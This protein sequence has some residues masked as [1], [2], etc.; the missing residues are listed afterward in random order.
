M[1]GIDLSLIVNLFEGTDRADHI[2]LTCAERNFEVTDVCQT[3]LNLRRDVALNLR[4][5][6][7]DVEHE[8]LIAVVQDVSHQIVA[9]H[10]GFPLAERNAVG[11]AIHLAQEP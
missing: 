6:I 2:N 11:G 7:T 9:S 5:N 10:L 1:F 4:H 3:F 8:D